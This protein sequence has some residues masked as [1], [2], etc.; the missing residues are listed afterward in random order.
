MVDDAV[1]DNQE[2]QQISKDE[3]CVAVKGMNSGKQKCLIEMAVKL[4]GTYIN[5][6]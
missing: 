4:K 2:L 1:R 3:V 6:S 5:K